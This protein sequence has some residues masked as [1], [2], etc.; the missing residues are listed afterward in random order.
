MLGTL[1]T[2]K[3]KGKIV[4]CDK[5]VNFRVHKWT[6]V[7]VFS[8]LRM[9]LTNTKAN[10]EELVADVHLL[11]ATAV[12]QTTM[13]A[14]K[15]YSTLDPILKTTILFEETKLGNM[16]SL[17]V[18]VLSSRR[19]ARLLKERLRYGKGGDWREGLTPCIR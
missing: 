13:D 9:I 16:P 17:I 4:L 2:E 5:R 7:K 8:K 12:G 18:A 14:I 3:V 6:A 1:I 11:P 10:N 15:F 19:P